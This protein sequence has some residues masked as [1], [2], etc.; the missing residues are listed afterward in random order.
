MA[1]PLFHKPVVIDQ[2][3]TVFRELHTPIDSSFVVKQE[4]G[5]QFIAPFHYHHGYEF[6]L[7]VR[8][9]GK[10]Y[11]GNRLMNFKDGDMYFFGP[12]FPHLFVNEKAFVQD[13]EQAH[14]VILQFGEDFIGTDFL[15]KPELKKVNE[16]LRLAHFGIKLNPDEEIKNLLFQLRSQKGVPALMMIIHLLDRVSAIEQPELTIINS[17]VYRPR[18][19]FDNMNKLEA[20]CQYVLENFKEDVNSKKAASIACLNEAAFCRYFKRRTQKTFSQFVNNVRIT[21]SMRLLSDKGLSITDVCFEC[22]FNNVSYFNRQFKGI[23]GKTP[24]EFRKEQRG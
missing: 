11:G 24:F 16:L 18:A 4:R 12:H 9:E 1:I 23:T 20:V 15:N 22:G 17:S 14:S 5:R 8:G 10:F 13:E 21:H 7:I 6:T 3:K 2:M 19:K